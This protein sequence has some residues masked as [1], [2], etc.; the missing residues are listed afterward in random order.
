MKDLKME[1][2]TRTMSTNLVG[3]DFII[4][5]LHG[6]YDLLMEKLEV[7]QFNVEEDRLF[8]VGDLVDRGPDSFKCISL[9]TESWF[10]AVEGN[11]E[12]MILDYMRWRDPQDMRRNGGEWFF[13]LTN[14][15]REYVTELIRTYMTHIIDTPDFLVTHARYC[16]DNWDRDLYYRSMAEEKSP[17]LRVGP[18][19]TDSII[20]YVGHNPVS[21]PLYIMDHMMI[22][23][24]ACFK[25]G[26][27]TMVEHK[28]A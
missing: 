26:Y 28:S 25:N 18:G 13:E 23:T 27:L 9:L 12:T 24:G 15:Q 22:D 17:G 4:G 14:E 3:R 7:V 5:D 10:Y 11:H 21:S 16:K 6:M 2:T 19:N 20:C 8:S 1:L